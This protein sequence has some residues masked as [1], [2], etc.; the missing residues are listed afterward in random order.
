MLCR[1]LWEKAHEEYHAAVSHESY[2]AEEQE[3]IYHRCSNNKNVMG[4]TN[5]FLSGFKAC[6]TG[7]NH[8]W[9]SMVGK[10]IGPRCEPT[11]IVLVNRH[12][13]RMTSALSSYSQLSTAFRHHWKIFFVEWTVVH[14]D[15]DY[16]LKCRK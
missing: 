14:T 3:D 16:C 9:W 15:T 8:V 7:R 13:I 5:C 4:I 1:L 6:P 11:N 2:N 12:R 10:L